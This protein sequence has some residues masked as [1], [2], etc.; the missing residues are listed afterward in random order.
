MNKKFDRSKKMNTFRR[1]LLEWEVK[2]LFFPWPPFI[3]GIFVIKGG[4]PQ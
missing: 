4:K 3:F 2:I 1:W